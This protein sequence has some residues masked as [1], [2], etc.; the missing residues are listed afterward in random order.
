MWQS[1]VRR[2]RAAPG[3]RGGGK[4]S[5]GGGATCDEVVA[6]LL[7]SAPL[8]QRLREREQVARRI[9][10]EAFFLYDSEEWLA[11]VLCSGINVLDRAVSWAGGCPT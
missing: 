11:Y 10:R 9:E 5:S 8:R 1:I 2:I 4:G 7:G 6:E 3:V